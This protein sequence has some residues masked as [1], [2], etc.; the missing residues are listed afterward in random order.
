[1]EDGLRVSYGYNETT[2]KALE[3]VYI[4]SVRDKLEFV[5]AYKQRY[6]K[7]IELPDRFRIGNDHAPFDVAK[8]QATRIMIA[9]RDRAPD[10]DS[11]QINPRAMREEGRAARFS[12][13]EP[14]QRE[15]AKEPESQEAHRCEESRAIRKRSASLRRQRCLPRPPLPTLRSPLQRKDREGDDRRVSRGHLPGGLYDNGFSAV[16]YSHED[17]HV[18]VQAR[19][20]RSLQG[21][22]GDLDA[23]FRQGCPATSHRLRDR[24]LAV[25]H[26]GDRPS[27]SDLSEMVL[28]PGPG[29]PVL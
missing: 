9:A 17:R 24:P 25:R 8:R 18:R 23:E 12:D 14:E 13:G 3:S 26:A 6:A 16:G 21:R 22:D 1:M 29:T 5:E 10:F 11:D 7:L 20:P 19:F 28:Q 27:G 15:P 2:S 4:R